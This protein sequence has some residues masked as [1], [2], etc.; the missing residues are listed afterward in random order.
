VNVETALT[1]PLSRR[2]FVV[3]GLGVLAGCARG[4]DADRAETTDPSVD[5]ADTTSSLTETTAPAPTTAESLAPVDSV[6]PTSDAPA[7]SA[8]TEPTGPTPWAKADFAALDSFFVDTDG[9]AVAI[10]EAGE[11]VHEWYSDGDSSFARDI[12]SAQKSV[13]SLLVG[14]AIDDGLLSLDTLVDSVIGDDW[15][16]GDTSTVTVFHLLTMT[17]GLDNRL[18]SR[19]AP[20]EA[21]LYSA[22]FAN[23]FTVVEQVSGLELN[24]FATTRLFDPIGAGGATFVARP[25]LPGL[26]GVGLEAT[27][28]QLAA[29]GLMVLG[30]RTPVV[31][32]AWLA[33]SFAPSQEL[34]PSYGLLWWLNGQPMHVVPEGRQ[35]DGP[36]IPTAPAGLVAALGKDD[37][38]LY[39]SREL[40]L[41]VTRLGDKADP[42]A[43]L[44]LSDFDAE[45]WSRLIAERDR[46]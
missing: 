41:V 36:L 25:D 5:E 7:T 21:W 31:S 46:A 35:I 13:L 1:S 2:L 29:V 34:N 27:A 18:R 39:V 17:S 24:E 16:R 19:A 44:A 38:K 9:Q 43:P 3:G 4:R 37:Q 32:E 20:G 8:A 42:S 40:D 10:Y 12:A 15:S 6:P 26:A 45:L 33:S 22:A 11:L 30:H 14:I 28:S 23:L